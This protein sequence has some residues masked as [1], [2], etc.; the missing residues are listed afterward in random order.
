M[1]KYSKTWKQVNQK[2]ELDREL[3]AKLAGQ[4]FD[5]KNFERE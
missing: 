4:D 3:E 2:N 1:N 5:T